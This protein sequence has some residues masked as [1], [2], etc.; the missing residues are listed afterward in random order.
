MNFDS[1]DFLHFSKA[2]ISQINK[3]HS[4]KN[5][6]N[7]FE[8]STLWYNFETRKHT[9][10]ELGNLNR[11]RPILGGFFTKKVIGLLESLSEVDTNKLSGLSVACIIGNTSKLSCLSRWMAKSL[12]RML[13]VYVFPFPA[14]FTPSLT[15][16][17]KLPTRWRPAKLEQII[18]ISTV[19][20]VE[21]TGD[22]YK[23]SCHFP[24]KICRVY[25]PA[26]YLQVL[27]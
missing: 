18:H 3:I 17:R 22:C 26:Q 8:V 23:C 12:T 25:S 7:D 6:K 9:C 11:R 21:N 15:W 20:K 19:C 10:S 5:G 27:W 24:R 2:V 13:N 1:Y 4:P 14:W 16:K